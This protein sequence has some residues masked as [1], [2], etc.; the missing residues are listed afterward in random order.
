MGYMRHTA[1]LVMTSRD[2]EREDVGQRVA[3]FRESMEP[4]FRPLLVGPIPSVVNN[5]AIY[6]F[7]PDGSKEGW[8][9]SDK[10]DQYRLAFRALFAQEHA[11]TCEVDFGGDDLRTVTAQ[12][13][14][15]PRCEE[16]GR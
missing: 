2:L 10:G 14:R 9:D 1:L 7:L 4:R 16:C 3:E 6:A 11:E 15:Y 5:Y 12:V 13:T 8:T